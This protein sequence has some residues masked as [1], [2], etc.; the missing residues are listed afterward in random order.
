M[1]KQERGLRTRQ[2]LIRSAAEV[3]EQRGYVQTR[4]ADISSQA[5]M[6]TGALHFHFPNKAAVAD[7]VEA[8]AAEALHRSARVAGRSPVNALQTLTDISHVFAFLLSHDVVVRA[9]VQLACDTARSPSLNFH[10]KWWNCVSRLLL[11]AADEGSL[12]DDVSLHDL[13]AVVVGATTGFLSLHRDNAEW[14]TRR[15]LTGFW[16][17]LLARVATPQVLGSLAPEGTG[18]TNTLPLVPCRPTLETC[19]QSGLPR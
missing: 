16:R 10:Q 15:S 4:L 7:A 5:G 17:L 12:A 2:V 14:L 11:Q 9:G 13:T 6:S 3:F 19:P 18:V 8:A 1:T